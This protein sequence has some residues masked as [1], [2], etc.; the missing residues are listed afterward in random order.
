MHIYMRQLRGYSAYWNQVKSNLMAFLRNLGPPTWFIT[1]SARDLEWPDMIN[2]LLHAR[3]QSNKK[4]RIKNLINTVTTSEIKKMPY[5]ERAKLLHDYPIV[6]AR[7]FNR[8]FKALMKY[9]MKDHQI[10][11][12][13]I[14]DYWY[15]IEFQ[16]RG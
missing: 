13:K 2:A 7:H 14:I 1:L 12:G 15:R 10:L 3:L 8:R 11:G 16:V 6:A 5:K 4:R 9:L